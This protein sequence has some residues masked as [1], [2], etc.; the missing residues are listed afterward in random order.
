MQTVRRFG[1]QESL[2]QSGWMNKLIFGDNV[3]AM[4]GLL[5]VLKDA[6][7]L[8]YIDP[9]FSTSQVFRSGKDRTATISYSDS[10]QTAYEDTKIGKEYLDFLR[11]RLLLMKELLSPTGSVYVHIGLGMSHR[12]R[13][14]MDEVFGADHF[15][16]EITRV[17]SNPK[18]FERPGFGNIKD[19][20]LFYSKSQSYVWNESLED[21]SQEDIERLFSK[22]DRQGRRYT[23]NP[24]HAPGETKNG[25]TGKPWRGMMP[26]KGRHWRYSPDVLDELERKG[27]I[28][29]SSTGNPRKIIYADEFIRKKK[30]RQDI[31]IFKDPPYPVYPTEKNLKMLK[32]I[33]EA[34]SN[35]GN[36]V[37]DCFAGSGT[38]LLAAEKTGRR[39]IGIDNSPVA[40]ETIV[41]RLLTDKDHQPFELIAAEEY[42]SRL[43]QAFQKLLQQ[44]S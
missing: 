5:P 21:Y 12:V 23:T 15:V 2:L 22:A 1:A 40:I 4:A 6:I 33:V 39:W 17:K 9:P 16:N 7:T 10:D 36:I 41:K 37:L 13:M 20:I 44:E 8:E 32:L 18:N 31:W 26:P 35:P 11:E 43:P 29:W 28:E 27:L 30:K 3:Q 14:L 25:R 34:S 42:V 19:T 24:L 38:T